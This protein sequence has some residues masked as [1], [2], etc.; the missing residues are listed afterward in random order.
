MI[1]R[2]L[3][4]GLSVP[5]DPP[6]PVDANAVDALAQRL[7]Q[8]SRRLLGRRLRLMPLDAGDCGGCAAELTALS[9]PLYRMERYG[10]VIVSTPAEADVL[11]VSGPMTR[12]MRHALDLALD[13]AGP[14]C[15]VMALGDCAVD[16]GVFKG[17]YAV[18][19][20]VGNA[21]QVDL[22]IGGCPPPPARILAGLRALLEAN[23]P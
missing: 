21:V 19:G 22:A 15:W 14:A 13:A 4:L 18:L 6:E 3:W 1:R 11:V 8:T 5:P 2:P 9:G 17:S 12:T 20:G 23:Q 16:G 7:R 10:L